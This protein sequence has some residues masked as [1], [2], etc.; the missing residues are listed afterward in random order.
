M[1]SR[2]SKIVVGLTLALASGVMVLGGCGSSTSKSSKGL[3]VESAWSRSTAEMATRGAMYATIVNDSGSDDALTSVS[4]PESVAKRTEL[5]ETKMASSMES[6]STT[7]AMGSM[8]GS[9]TMTMSPVDQISVKD[10]ATVTLKPG[11][12]HVMLMELAA[13]LKSGQ[14]FDATLKFERAGSKKVTVTVKDMTAKG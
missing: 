5:H 8:G 2:N 6:G 7:S 10:G 1:N 9:G 12:Y 14:K 13:P 4:V 3:S 11:G